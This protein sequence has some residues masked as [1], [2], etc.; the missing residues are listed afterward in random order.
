M[1]GRGKKEGCRA[2]RWRRTLKRWGCRWWGCRPRNNLPPCP[3]WG[4]CSRCCIL[5]RWRFRCWRSWWCRR[6]WRRR[7]WGRG[8]WIGIIG[9]RASAAFCI[10]GGWRIDKWSC[11]G[12]GRTTLHRVAARCQPGETR[13]LNSTHC[14]LPLLWSNWYFFCFLVRFSW[15][16]WKKGNNVLCPFRHELDFASGCGDHHQDER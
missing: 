10:C 4:M 14:C 15:I 11:I 8:R 1:R 6:R 2:R 9:G 5:D 16:G 12:Q 7:G 13:R 3:R